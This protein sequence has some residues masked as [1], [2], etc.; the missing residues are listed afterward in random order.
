MEKRCP[1][2][3]MV[4][5]EDATV[6]PCGATLARQDETDL[7]GAVNKKLRNLLV[8]SGT[9]LFIV[10]AVSFLRHQNGPATQDN[11]S[12][13]WKTRELKD[14]RITLEAPGPF[15]AISMEDLHMPKELRDKLAR[16]DFYALANPGFYVMAG[17]FQVKNLADFPPP[18][19]FLP[20]EAEVKAGNKAQIA[21]CMAGSTS[22]IMFEDRFTKSGQAI[23]GKNFVIASPPQMWLVNVM[24]VEA[25]KGA[26]EEAQRIVDSIRIDG[27]PIV[28]L[29]SPAQG[30]AGG[31]QCRVL[32]PGVLTASSPSPWTEMEPAAVA[33]DAQLPCRPPDGRYFMCQCGPVN[34]TVGTGA[35]ADD[36]SGFVNDELKRANASPRVG[37]LLGRR[38]V[39][40]SKD[41]ELGSQKWISRKVV[42]ASRTRSWI[43]EAQYPSDDK[44]SQEL[45][46]RVQ[47]S[48][49]ER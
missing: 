33:L 32:V 35:C 14:A 18:S 46:D 3:G 48:L 8:W 7:Q 22:G 11:H 9:F 47:A 15:Q 2:C 38:A 44:A 20:P 49:E 27:Q 4:N 12:D 28:I 26:E 25:D 16:S 30:L 21:L 17:R 29:E 31:W 19:A 45:V 43:F 40:W 34:F 10:A 37:I 42:A 5:P 6:C 1:A 39:V 13:E 41:S 23:V 24:H 36:Q